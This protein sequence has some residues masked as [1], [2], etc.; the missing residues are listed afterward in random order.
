MTAVPG[1][2]WRKHEVEKRTGKNAR[3]LAFIHPQLTLS[4]FSDTIPHLAHCLH[5]YSVDFEN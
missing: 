3:D 4:L 2:A 5:A 1:A